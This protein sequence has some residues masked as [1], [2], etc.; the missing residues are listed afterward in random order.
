MSGN[1]WILNSKPVASPEVRLFC[2]SYAGR[3][4]SAF[5]SWRDHLPPTVDLCAIQLP[6][7]ETRLREPLE[8]RLQPLV[9]AIVNGMS[10]LLDVPYALFGHSMGSLLAFE[11]AHALRAAGKPQATRLFVSGREAPHVA[12]V[13]P[14]L[15]ALSD[16]VF[17]DKLQLLFGGIPEP[18]R[19][20]P[21]LMRFYL[22]VIRADLTVLEQ[23]RHEPRPPLD[24]PISAFRGTTDE[25][26]GDA[27]FQAWGELTRAEFRARSLAGG[28]FFINDAPAR[29]DMI[30]TMLGDLGNTRPAAAAASPA[31]GRNPAAQAV[32]QAQAVAHVFPGQGSQQKGMGA[33][34]FDRY[35]ALVAKADEILGYSLRT[36]CL[37]DPD[38]RLAQTEYTQPALFVVNALT[39]LAAV[40]DGG[41]R[42]DLVAGHSLGEYNA[43]LAA[44]VFDFETGL[45]LVAK[46][47]QLM[48]QARRGAMAAVID[49]PPDDIARLLERNGLSSI[50]VA[51]LNTPTQ[52]VI[53]GPVEDI[54]RA[55]PVFRQAGAKYI[56]LN[57][58]A[59][60]HS[61]YMT[62]AEREFAAFMGGFAFAPPAIPVI[63]NHTARPY[64]PNDIRGC[65]ARQ[66]SSSV[67]WYESVSY[68]IATAD[69]QFVE[70]GPGQVLTRMIAQI[71][72][73]P[74]PIAPDPVPA[75]APAVAVPEPP[76][77]SRPAVPPPGGLAFLLSGQGSQYFRMG[78]ALYAGD[79]VFRGAMDRCARLAGDG[80]RLTDQ[81]YRGAAASE[82]FDDPAAAS[83]ALVAIGHAL[84]AVL[85]ERGIVPDLLV[86]YGVGE[87]AAAVVSGAVALE[88]GIGFAAETARLFQRVTPAAGLLAV[89]D[90]PDL[91]ERRPDLFDGCTVA[92][93]HFHR[94]FLVTGAASAV[95]RAAER[96]RQCDVT[97]QILPA[98]IGLHSALID[99]AEDEFRRLA[100]GLAVKAP[101]LPLFSPAGIGWVPAVGPDSLWRAVRQPVRF[102]EAVLRMEAEAR[103]RRYVD[104]GPSGTLGT[105]V[106]YQLND[107]GRAVIA[108]NRFGRDLECLQALVD[109]L[110]TGGR[111]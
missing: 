49:L 39:H 47:G 88:D 95:R 31:V 40:A 15:S 106:K 58:S 8:T 67:R 25:Q 108:M 69:P 68:M 77:P 107:A 23:Y 14:L 21:E 13:P 75:P 43:L 28:H 91:V 63:A 66:I 87:I 92:A 99:E 10:T 52:T 12:R 34:L 109:A 59:A 30:Q 94:H 110:G 60:F 29:A 7:H 73:S 27:G 78:A 82:L 54:P 57:V 103:P 102:G 84:A 70:I 44:E 50:D 100:A 42:P 56:Q 71:R 6:G 111:G 74:M 51:N 26:V 5:V 72:Q 48:K 83:V 55:E 37:E 93:V 96:L 22:P 45:R 61:R 20:D 64:D 89:L 35:P 81:L 33:A 24:C 9:D 86:G 98:R 79:A 16:S 90:H 36:L 18:V 53:A 19:N 11:V 105:F 46:R 80:L 38:R 97:A 41:V 101:R 17:L 2:F 1:P 104:A 76:A 32:A 65:L 3:G 85:E 62:E 4:A